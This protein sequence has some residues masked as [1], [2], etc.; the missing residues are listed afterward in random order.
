[1]NCKP[2]ECYEQKI[3]IVVP[4][5]TRKEE[6]DG[7]NGITIIIMEGVDDDDRYV[8]M[9]GAEGISQ[10]AVAGRKWQQQQLNT[11]QET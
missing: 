3:L 11:Q 4:L 8:M 7:K 10:Q 1:M 9:S 5:C 6:E 2:E